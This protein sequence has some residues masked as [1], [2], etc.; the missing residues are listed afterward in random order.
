MILRRR[1]ARRGAVAAVFSLAPQGSG[2]KSWSAT[3]AACRPGR[4][5]PPWF[6]PQGEPAM[7]GGS[8]AAP[9]C[10]AL[11]GPYLSGKTSLL[12]SLLFVTGAI[13]RKGSAREGNTVGDGT[14]EARA[15]Q[16]STELNVASTT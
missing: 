12:E 8:A 10:A 11:I 9:R 3:R 15:R 4:K 7:G 1:A 14:P 2:L 6:Q 16:M 5:P 13:G